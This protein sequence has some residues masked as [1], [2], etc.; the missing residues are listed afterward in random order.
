MVLSLLLSDCP[1]VICFTKNVSCWERF[2]IKLLIT[3]CMVKFCFE[4]SLERTILLCRKD[5]LKFLE[6]L[7]FA[8]NFHKII[9]CRKTQIFFLLRKKETVKILFYQHVSEEFQILYI[10]KRKSINLGKG[11]G[12]K[13]KE[14]ALQASLPNTHAYLTSGISKTTFKN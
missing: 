14:M 11:T 13:L 9:Y 7:Q 3:T 6:I 10:L 2:R 12:L 4:C 1:A 8:V 5:S